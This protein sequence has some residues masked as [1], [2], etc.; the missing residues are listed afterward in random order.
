MPILIRAI[1]HITLVMLAGGFAFPIFV[2]RAQA[3]L[4]LREAIIERRRAWLMLLVGLAAVAMALDFSLHALL[5]T[6]QTVLEILVRLAPLGVLGWLIITAHDDSIFALAVSAL[7][8]L[9]QSLISHAAFERDP[10]LPLAADWVHLICVSL[11]LG[12][13]GYYAAV[14][15]PVVMSQTDL[16]GSLMG[17]LGASLARF[18]PLA[19][20]CVLVVAL[21]GI[22]QGTTFVVSL[23]KLVG[24][25]Y[26]RA[27]MVKLLV[28]GGLVAFGAFH[29]LVITPKLGAWRRDVRGQAQA[30]RRFRI[31]VTA[32]LALSLITLVAA[33]AMTVLPLARDAIQ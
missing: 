24:T 17:G 27:L 12:G 33:A 10:L 1:V 22:I 7:V 23:E 3:T 16:T 30:A 5:A 9:N 28:F 8:L 25:D 11:W 13:V 15:V 18:S 6:P 26:G 20:L 4:A 14:I 19:T 32:E 21:T 29:Q 2:F 31:S